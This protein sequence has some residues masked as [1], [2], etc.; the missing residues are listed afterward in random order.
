M[1]PCNHELP[2]AT[3][4]FGFRLGFS[5][6]VETA[7]RNGPISARLLHVLLYMQANMKFPYSHMLI[8]RVAGAF[9]ILG[10]LHAQTGVPIVLYIKTRISV[11]FTAP[12]YS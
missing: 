5:P 11:A 8:K 10:R 12:V 9:A 1:R 7:A 4:L 3:T 2:F 6:F